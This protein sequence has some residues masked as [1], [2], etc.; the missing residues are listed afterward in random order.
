MRGCFVSTHHFSEMGHTVSI[1]RWS[2]YKN[3]IFASKSFEVS[4]QVAKRMREKK[5]CKKQ[6]SQGHHICRDGITII[7]CQIHNISSPSG[8]VS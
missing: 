5:E 8:M 3:T 4:D 7:A 1:D 6:Y 2:K